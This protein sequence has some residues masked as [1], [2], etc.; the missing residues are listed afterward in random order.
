MAIIEAADLRKVF[1]RIVRQP[2]IAGA[3]GALFSREYEDKVAV[4]DVSFSLAEGE[5]VG[6]LGPNGAGKSTTIKMLTGILVPTSGL[7]RVA[8]IV[9]SAHRQANAQNIGVVF[10]QRSQLYWDLPLRESFELLRSIYDVPRDRYLQ[11]MRH[12]AEI[13]DL[14]RFLDTPVRQLSLGE[15]MRGDFAAAMLHDPKIVYLDEPTIGLDVVAKEAIRVFIGQI[16]RERGTTVILTTHDLA[17]VER[18]TPR[19]I[20]IDEG[21]VIYDGALE[22]LRTEYGTH[23]IL[24]VTTVDLPPEDFAVPGAVVEGRE[25]NVVRLGFDRRSLTAEALIRRVLERYA[26]SDVSIIEPDIDT[27]VRRIYLEGYQK[28][29]VG[30]PS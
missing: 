22:R 7:L 28:D 27:I 29:A 18:L 9:P 16:N 17:D 3:I 11:N 2:G 25:N 19:I 6:Y 23:R 30:A 12:F 14:E 26:I 4:D 24:V 10:G 20:L 8:G 1:R 15:R 13:L 21:R 5:L